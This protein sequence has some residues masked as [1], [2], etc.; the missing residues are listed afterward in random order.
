MYCVKWANTVDTEIYS[1][2][3][4]QTQFQLSFDMLGK[5]SSYS[6]NFLLFILD[7]GKVRYGNAFI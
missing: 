6:G 5:V 3:K 1:F 2:I 7:L 4:F